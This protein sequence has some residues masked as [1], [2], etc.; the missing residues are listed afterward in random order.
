MHTAFSPEPEKV[1]FI[2]R[3]Q[4]TIELLKEAGRRELSNAPGHIKLGSVASRYDQPFFDT[5]DRPEPSQG[6][7]ESGIR[8]REPFSNFDARGLMA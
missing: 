8:N 6:L 4:P 3:S 7:R 1:R 2:V 5:L